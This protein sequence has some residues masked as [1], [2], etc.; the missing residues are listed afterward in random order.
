MYLEYFGLHEAPFS[1]TPDTSYFFADGHYRDALDTLLVA[2]K[3]GEGFIKVTGEVGTGKTLLCRKLLNTLD[4]GFYTAYVPNPFLTAPALNL[5][6]ADELGLELPRNLGQHRTLKAITRRLIELAHKGKQV[7]LCVDEAQAMPDETLE[8]LRLLTN[9]ETE[10]RK[11]LQVVLF[12]QPELD[13]RLGRASIRQLRQRITFSFRLQPMDREAAA[14][15]LNHRLAVAGSRGAIRF[16]AG[17]LRRLHKASDGIPRLI[18]ILAHKAL[19]A[20]YGKGTRTVTP[21]HV[22]MAVADTESA[23]SATTKRWF[24]L[25]LASALTLGGLLIFRPDLPVDG[26]TTLAVGNVDESTPAVPTWRLVRAVPASLA[27][28]PQPQSLYLEGV[29]LERV[30]SVELQ[31]G[32]RRET[33][34]PH[35]IEYIDGRHLRITVTT[36]VDS[37][38][39]SARAVA[40]TGERSNPITFTVVGPGESLADHRKEGEVEPT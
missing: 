30:H 16:N 33:L 39:W 2:L 22:G 37:G 10:K 8:A 18:N 29:G 36:G 12:G 1:L 19:M 11:L 27:G 21:K 24:W 20:A 7:V 31:R 17:A 38:T 4:D 15:Y 9:L 6:L 13:E 14:A 28:S 5:A 34:D 26:T 25:P 35:R 32:A 23:H 3:G 40:P